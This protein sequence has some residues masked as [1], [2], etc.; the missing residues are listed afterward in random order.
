M[1]LVAVDN[2]GFSNKKDFSLTVVA[3]D[4]KAPE[5]LQDKT[6]VKKLDTGKYEVT[7][8]FTD[9]LSFVAK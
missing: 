6:T 8:S 7:L 3:S 2:E 5:I 4:S 9:N 1:S